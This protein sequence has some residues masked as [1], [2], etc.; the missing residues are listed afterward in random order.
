MP[1]VNKQMREVSAQAH[2][3]SII[4]GLFLFTGRTPVQILSLC[5]ICG[6]QN[7]APIKMPDVILQMFLF[8]GP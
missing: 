5:S 1:I 7:E 4:I 8:P 3:K 2:I 6:L